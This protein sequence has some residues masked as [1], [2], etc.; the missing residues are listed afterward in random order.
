MKQQLNEVKRMQQ[1]AGLTTK[2]RY[3]ELQLN[4][5][6]HSKALALISNELKRVQGNEELMDNS[7]DMHDMID[8][9]MSYVKAGK[10]DKKEV[11]DAWNQYNSE[12]G[13]YKP[14]AK[15]ILKAILFN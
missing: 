2:S 8:S 4:E 10:I 13:D 11:E 14:L 5:D 7:V 1:L 3:Q 12:N 9:L 15:L 6:T